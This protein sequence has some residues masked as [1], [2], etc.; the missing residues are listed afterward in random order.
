MASSAGDV[1]QHSPQASS[2]Q[3]TEIGKLRPNELDWGVEVCAAVD[4]ETRSSQLP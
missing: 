4:E 1:S 3:R 2:V